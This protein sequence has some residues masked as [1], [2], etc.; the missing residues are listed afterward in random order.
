MPK[1]ILEGYVVS[2]S[3]NKTIVVKVNRS[4]R[5]KKYKKVVTLSKKYS[6]HDEQNKSKVGDKVSIIESKPISKT[7]RW[8]LIDSASVS[9]ENVG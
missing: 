3:S 1:K 2:T 8:M 6:A 4:I 5:H 7:K 9:F